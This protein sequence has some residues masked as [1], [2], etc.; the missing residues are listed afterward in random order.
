MKINLKFYSILSAIV[1]SIGLSLCESQC[2]AQVNNSTVNNFE[3]EKF[4]GKWYELARYDHFFEKGLTD[5][6]ADYSLLKDGK[7]RVVN[8]GIKNGRLKEIV[9]K[10]KY[11]DPQKHPG[12]LAVSFFLWFYSDY[13]V[14]Y[15]DDDYL[16]T[17]ITSS[18]DKYLWIMSRTPTVSDAE[19]NALL[20]IVKDRGYDTSKLIID[21]Q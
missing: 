17:I 7:I 6:T 8:R 3:I 21:R 13:Y 14:M 12:K 18:S 10:A 9:G 5:V 4:V 16:H 19:F 1:G 11:P 2:V 15:V 20:Q